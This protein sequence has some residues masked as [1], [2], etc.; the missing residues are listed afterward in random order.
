M[1][2]AQ[3]LYCYLTMICCLMI[4]LPAQAVEK[5]PL[6]HVF[7]ISVGGLN[8]EGFSSTATSNMNYLA[9][10]GIIDRQALAIRTDTMESAETSLLTGAEASVHKHFT[11]ND[12]V[13][14][15]SIFDILN[16]NARTILVVDGSGGKL[17]S[18]AHG[19]ESYR[20][21]K[22]SAG[23]KEILAEAYSSFQKNK[24]FFTYIYID[25]CSEALLRQDHKAYQTAI[26]K[27]DTELGVFLK[28]LHDSGTYKDALIVVTSARSSSSSNQVPIIIAGP[29]VK[30]NSVIG[31]SMIIDMASTICQLAELDVPANSRGIPMYSAF[32]V[33]EGEK[34]KIHDAWIK[35]LQKDRLANWD[36]NY[37]MNDELSRT[38]HQMNAIKEEK[39]SIFDFAGEREQLIAG[40]K[41]K[42]TLERI[43]WCGMIVLLLLGYI[44]EY[45][46][47]KK[48][49][50]AI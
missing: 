20:K 30:V 32:M 26:R 37:L 38:V 41:S 34:E 9:G 44:G 50:P 14:A 48:K 19:Q 46:W 3:G 10:E 2:F 47:L 40:L 22:P 17:Q 25:D 36:M 35:A 23:S 49:V 15:E 21:L 5:A 13:E 43:I 42:L 28:Q 1:G 31:G 18:F 16:K 6:K 45:L 12:S 39:Q 8:Q 11:A 29:G 33:A 7:L 24:P 4:G 27:F